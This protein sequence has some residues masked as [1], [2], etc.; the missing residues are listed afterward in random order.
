MKPG[1]YRRDLVGLHRG[2]FAPPAADLAE[3]VRFQ[4]DERTYVDVAVN[5]GKLVVRAGGSGRTH[6]LAVLPQGGVNTIH[7]RLEEG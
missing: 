1:I 3:G 7:I 4:L 2:E 5:Y 6:Q